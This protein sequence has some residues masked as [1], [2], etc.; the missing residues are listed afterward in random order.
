MKRGRLPVRVWLLLFSAAIGCDR[1]Q[2][3]ARFTHFPT[4]SEEIPEL[5]SAVPPNEG[6]TLAEGTVT[7]TM[8][9]ASYTYIL[10]DT[11]EKKIWAAAPQLSV[12]VGD[13]VTVPA[14][15]AMH[16]FHSN[17]LNRD[18][19]V[20]YFVSG[21][22]NESSPDGGAATGSAM[23]SAHQPASAAATPEDIDLSEIERP[24]GGK[25]VEE[26]HSEKSQLA[27]KKITVRGKV[28]KFNGQIMGRNWLHIRD[29]SGDADKGTHDLTVTSG[30]TARPGDTVVVSGELHKDRDFGFGYKYG[31]IVEDAEVTI[32]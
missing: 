22:R 9:A 20:I 10:V 29:G 12:K 1:A 2:P 3:T 23:Q 24:E 21:V 11:G 16:D 15:M 18:F 14:G 32:E 8:D 7:E 4:H 27:G 5:D 6:G 26:V 25:T 19:D 28:V 30:A 17:T 31:V 13:K